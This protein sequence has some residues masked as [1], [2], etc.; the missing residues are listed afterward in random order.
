[1]ITSINEWKKYQAK[2]KIVEGRGNTRIRFEGVNYPT[3]YID[4]YGTDIDEE[5]GE[6]NE[7][8]NDTFLDD[9]IGNLS[10]LKTVSLEKLAKPEYMNNDSAIYF[11]N[12]IM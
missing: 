8:V 5:T 11:E 12:N 4:Y 10:H 1:M 2:N 7:N 9:V 3:Y 6:E